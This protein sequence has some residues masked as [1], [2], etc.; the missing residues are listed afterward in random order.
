[1]EERD[2]EKVFKTPLSLT[3][4]EAYEQF[5]SIPDF[6]GHKTIDAMNFLADAAIAKGYQRPNLSFCLIQTRYLLNEKIAKFVRDHSTDNC[7]DVKTLNDADKKEFNDLWITRE[8]LDQ[9]E[10]NLMN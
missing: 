8:I 7:F 4:Y 10:T 5:L 9:L 2:E 1:M 6:S 3:L